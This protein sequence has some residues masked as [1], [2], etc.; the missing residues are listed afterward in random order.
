MKN[1]C[2]MRVWADKSNI[3]CCCS[4]ACQPTH[5]ASTWGTLIFIKG[6]RG[7]SYLTIEVKWTPPPNFSIS[8][9]EFIPHLD[10]SLFEMQNVTAA[11]STILF[12]YSIPIKK[13]HISTIIALVIFRREK[14]QV[15]AMPIFFIQYN[16]TNKQIRVL[17]DIWTIDSYFIKITINFYQDL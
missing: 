13:A 15:V 8:K 3:N 5:V 6:S 12:N 11:C 7:S 16:R 2:Y 9:F 4:E 10:I 1:K 17:N 14:V